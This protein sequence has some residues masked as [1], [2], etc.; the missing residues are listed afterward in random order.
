MPH[1]DTA[2]TSNRLGP[3]EAM[4]HWRD[5]FARRQETPIEVEV[6]ESERFDAFLFSRGIGQ[7]RMLHMR[8]PAQRV[9]HHGTAE[10]LAAGD[11][12]VHL[13]YPLEGSFTGRDPTR[14]FAIEPGQ[15]VMMDN[16]R[17]FELECTA[18]EAID[19]IMPLPW[20]EQHVPDPLTLLS[21]AMS[22]R[23]HWA[24]PLGSLLETI[25]RQGEDYPVPRPLVA[26]QLGHLLALAIGVRE[27]SAGRRSARLA[28]RIMQRIESD[29]SDPELS[30]VGVAA[31]LGISKRY[32]Q[33]LLAGSGTSFV[34]ELNA[35]RLDRA[36]IL[37]TDPR[38]REL[39]VAEIAF[40]CG[41]LDPAYF[42][43]QFR[44]RF[45]ATPRGW[46]A[47]N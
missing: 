15:F 1:R 38:T 4:E 31:D 22:M 47:M 2:W 30:P 20:L 42:A 39:P 25:A 3:D 10:D 32:L 34:R 41:F 16:S 35:V 23:E 40:R 36:N 33:S 44:K 29:Y 13:L 9:I 19:L 17:F 12:L 14:A 46:R 45:N 8:A 5:I 24:P 26:E 27:P 37:L 21:R 11:R 18:H 28:Q 7:L 6:L 43:R